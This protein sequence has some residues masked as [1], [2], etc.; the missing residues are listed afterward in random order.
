V[1]QFAA[2]PSCVAPFTLYTQEEGVLCVCEAVVAVGHPRIGLCGAP[3][4]CVTERD[5][6]I[7]IRFFYCSPFVISID[8]T[9]PYRLVH[10]LSVWRGGFNTYLYITGC[11]N[12]R[13]W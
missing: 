12:F 5:T 8:F 3:S 4:V 9:E 13:A 11:L 1:T 10:F 6:F 2:L 7:I